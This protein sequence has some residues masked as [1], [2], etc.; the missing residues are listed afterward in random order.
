MNMFL[1]DQVLRNN[2]VTN[3]QGGGKKGTWGTT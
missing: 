1:T 3:S 2:T